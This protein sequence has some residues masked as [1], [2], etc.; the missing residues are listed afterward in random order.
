M[1]RNNVLRPAWGLF[2]AFLLCF[3]ATTPGAAQSWNL[4]GGQYLTEEE[5]KRLSEDEALEYCEK[6]AQEIDI[7]NDNAAAANSM[8]SDIDTEISR[9]RESLSRARAA[10][11][12]LA[13]EVADLEAKLRKLQ[14]LPR[15]YTVVP[16]DF[17][18]KI[19]EMRRIYGDPTHWKRIYRANRQEIRD[20]NLIFPDQVFLIPRGT[21]TQHVVAQGEWL[22]LIAGY[23]EVYGDR[24][25]WP[26]L[27]EANRDA[28][29]ADPEILAPGTVL[30]IPR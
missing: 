2:A 30:H 13:R 22:A 14:E 9:L 23:S 18:I 4:S 24:L 12:P 16:G 6:L 1:N 10:N 28:I 11:D 20:P 8:L 17:L 21:P 26:R 27:Y 3:G 15:S 7:Q 5:Y 29:G 25:Q 19:S